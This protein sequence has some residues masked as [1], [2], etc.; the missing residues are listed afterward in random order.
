MAWMHLPL[1]GKPSQ[2]K[3]FT[4]T[5]EEVEVVDA[6]K[7]VAKISLMVHNKI[8]AKRPVSRQQSQGRGSQRGPGAGPNRQQNAADNRECWGCGEKGHMQRDSPKGKASGKKEQGNY[9]STSRDA[10]EGR[11]ERMFVI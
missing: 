2:S 10:S 7:V 11:S 9:A 4:L 1:K 8:R 5:L 3:L 6:V